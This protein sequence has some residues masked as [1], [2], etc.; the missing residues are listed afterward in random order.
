MEKQHITLWG[1]HIAQILGPLQHFFKGRGGGVQHCNTEHVS[2]F[3]LKIISL[4]FKNHK[5]SKILLNAS[6]Y[7]QTNQMNPLLFCL[8][9]IGR[10][11]NELSLPKSS[12]KVGQLFIFI[13]LLYCICFSSRRMHTSVADCLFKKIRFRLIFNHVYSTKSL[14][15]KSTF[16]GEI[17]SIKLQ[18][19]MLL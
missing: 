1:N 16:I 7:H 8:R 15:A 14:P 2:T 19:Y 6:V 11:V 4:T 12:N 9:A 3:C 5:S 17:N 10:G 18:I 13:G